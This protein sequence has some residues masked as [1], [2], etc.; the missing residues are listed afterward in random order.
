[1]DIKTELIGKLADFS[2]HEAVLAVYAVMP[3]NKLMVSLKGQSKALERDYNSM[4]L[5]RADYNVESEKLRQGLSYVIDRLTEADLKKVFVAVVQGDA[6][7]DEP[8]NGKT[9][10]FIAASPKDLDNLQITFEYALIKDTL[11]ASA[12]RDKFVFKDP[13][14][15]AT[16]DSMVDAINT[17]KPAIIHFSGHAGRKGVVLSDRDNKAELIPTAILDRYFSTFDTGTDCVFL[18][19]CYSAEQAAVISKYAKYVIGMNCPFGDEAAI[20]FSEAFYR[21]L[22]NDNALDY[23]KAFKQARVKLQLRANEESSTPE[24]WKNRKNVAM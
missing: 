3:A 14:L 5:S 18:N 8:H 1:M 19:A 2:I 6:N 21:C 24:I 23:E 20:T 9:M 12:N 7:G 16:I 17:S 10:L 15:A 22:F 4:L 13:V 11:V